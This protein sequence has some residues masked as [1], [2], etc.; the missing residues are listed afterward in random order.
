M[1]KYAASL[2]GKG[3]LYCEDRCHHWCSEPDARNSI[4]APPRSAGM[5]VGVRGGKSSLCRLCW[6]GWVWEARREEVQVLQKRLQP[7]PVW[8]LPGLGPLGGTAAG[9]PGPCGG[10]P[11]RRVLGSLCAR[12]E[13]RPRG[14]R[15]WRPGRAWWAGPCVGLRREAPGRGQCPGGR[16]GLQRGRDGSSSWPRR[17]ASETSFFRWTLQWEKSH[18]KSL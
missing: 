16:E 4:A 18:K 11:F 9:S 14:A 15:S 3:L 5:G 7:S 1:D 12:R 17:R 8:G 2:W 10:P 13:Q 6:G